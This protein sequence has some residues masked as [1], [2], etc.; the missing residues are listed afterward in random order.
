MLAALLWAPAALSPEQLSLLAEEQPEGLVLWRGRRQVWGGE[1]AAAH[2]EAPRVE[3]QAPPSEQPAAN[4][5]ATRVGLIDDFKRFLKDAASTETALRETAAG[6]RAYRGWSLADINRLYD[7]GHPTNNI[8][9]AGLLIHQHDNTERK[10]ENVYTPGWKF[11]YHWATSLINRQMPGLYNHEC[12]VILAPNEVR[13]TLNPN[14]NP[15]PNAKPKPK[16][17][18]KP[19][20]N[21][22]HQAR[23]LCSYYADF[24]SWTEGCSRR[25][26]GQGGLR[27]TRRRWID[28]TPVLDHEVSQAGRLYLDVSPC[29]SPHLPISTTRSRRPAAA[30]PFTRT[31]TL[32]LNAHPKRPPDPHASPI[33]KPDPNP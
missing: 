22:N 20:P 8:S 23:V 5:P 19:N 18:P 4:A 21:P 28:P 3:A 17:N 33:S 1:T 31:R 27:L 24:V 12:G 10:G 7:T 25:G 30:Q 32:T 15:K 11:R 9:E 2:E 13:R 14:P 6:G 16:T 29:I 26:L